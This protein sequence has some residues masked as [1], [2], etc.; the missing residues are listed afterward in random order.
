[1]NQ[2]EGATAG[3]RRTPR[4]AG[5]LLP[6]CDAPREWQRGKAVPVESFSATTT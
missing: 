4:S 1:M 5:Y 6:A 3:D 2:P